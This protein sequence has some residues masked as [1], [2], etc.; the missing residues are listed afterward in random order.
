MQAT[1]IGFQDRYALLQLESN[2]TVKW[3]ITQLPHSI[4]T[5]DQ[6]KIKILTEQE[7]ESDKAKEMK[8]I[9]RELIN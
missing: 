3:P 4:Q 6:I 2:D 5:G 9:L 7:L 8:E 1:I